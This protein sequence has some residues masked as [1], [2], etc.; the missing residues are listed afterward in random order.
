MHFKDLPGSIARV[1]FRISVPD[2]V[3][4]GFRCRKSTV[5]DLSINRSINQG[6]YFTSLL[7]RGQFRLE[8]L[9]RFGLDVFVGRASERLRGF[10]DHL[11]ALP[12][13]LCVR[14]RRC[15]RVP[16]VHCAPSENARKH[17]PG[18]HCFNIFKIVVKFY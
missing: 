10:L 18:L 1:G 14:H 4:H 7:A 11:H 9:E 16:R 13:P 5:M 12:R 6:A 8:H 17:K 2:F 3:L 15:L